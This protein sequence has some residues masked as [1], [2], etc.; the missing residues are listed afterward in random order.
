SV[1]YVFFRDLRRKLESA[2]AQL[3]EAA[4]TD[5]LTGIRNRRFVLESFNAEIAEAARTQAPLCCAITDADDFKRVNDELGHGSGD[6]ALKAIASILAA[7]VRPYDIA[8]RYG[9][10]EFI[11]VFPHTSKAEALAAC[12]RLRRDV[13][14]QASPRVPGL[15]RPLTISIGIAELQS[16]DAGAEALLARADAGLY[17]AKAAGKNRCAY[18]EKT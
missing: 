13:E 2:R 11:L 8:G 3:E 12:E 10:E 5:S 16:G 14:S 15:K 18:Q 9:G 4:T 7:G 1:I 6:L 17:R